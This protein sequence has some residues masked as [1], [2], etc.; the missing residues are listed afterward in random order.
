M[1]TAD[2]KLLA[3]KNSAGNARKESRQ[4]SRLAR[5]PWM[6]YPAGRMLKTGLIQPETIPGHFPRNLRNIV[7]LY[8]SCLDGGAE[9][10]LCPP[11]ALSGVHTGEL[12]LRSGFRSQH[13][14]ALAYLAREI[15]EVPLLLGA[16]DAEGIRFYLLRQGLSFPQQTLISHGVPG[17]ESVSVSGVFRTADEAGFSMIPWEG[18]SPSP[19]ACLLLRTPS[20]AWHEGLLE[21]DER[22]AR[23]LS[24]ETGL[25]VFTSR[26]AGGEGPFL[27][28]GASSVWD[29]KGFLLNRLR[30]FE[31]D[32]AVI[33][34]EKPTGTAS[35]LPAP[36]EQLRHAL[37][38]GTADFI[39]K[40]GH[41]SVCLNLLESPASLLLAHLLKE[42]LPSLAVRG[43]LPRLPGVPERDIARAQAFADKLD[44]H[45]RMLPFP[46][47]TATGGLD[48]LFTAAWRM[49]QWAQEEGALPVSALNGTDIMTAPRLL[50]AALAADFMPLGDLYET[51]LADLFPGFLTPTPDAAMRDSLLI[52]LHR[53]HDSA[54]P[55]TGLFPESETEIRRL[56]RQARSSEWMRRKLPPRLMLRSIPDAPETPY[57]HRLMD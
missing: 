46:A 43:F 24:R 8:R 12:A 30:L 49:R 31:R 20:G 26:P 32:S 34:P 41:G 38:K 44:I 51:E 28:P 18:I 57:V 39:L 11:L 21:Q 45:A 16:A 5:H 25:P 14:A 42:E 17:T 15:T 22:E 1:K 33:A 7:E 37:R 35:S 53:A 40:T 9:L 56:Q 2:D 13:R 6:V 48:D 54:T 19:A 23:R 29:G 4:A 27:L 52:R 50:P 55:L 3:I 47:D 36:Q 10:V